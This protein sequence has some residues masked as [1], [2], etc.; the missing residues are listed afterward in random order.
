M[1]NWLEPVGPHAPGVYWRRRALALVL[2]VGLLLAVGRACGAEEGPKLPTGNNVAGPAP[3]STRTPPPT[4]FPASLLPTTPAATTAGTPT[5]GSGTLRPP[6]AKK[7][8][9]AAP[10]VC[11]KNAIRVSVRA[12]ARRYDAET[13]P[14]FTLAVTNAGRTACRFDLG[15]EA[16]SL[17]VISGKDRIWSSDDCRRGARSE[18]K[19]L[20]PGQSVAET[21][22]WNRQRSRPG[23]PSG[24]PTPRPGT[25]V[26]DGA[27]GG[28]QPERKTVFELR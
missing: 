21:V 23:C 10:P 19:L 11:A 3:A 18:V 7:T 8:T 27:A 6:A 12:D 16:L 24:L 5:G 14:R 25:Y 26:V 9:P 20:K 17:V 22:V 1:S 13:K 15:S 4:T 2:V 28:V